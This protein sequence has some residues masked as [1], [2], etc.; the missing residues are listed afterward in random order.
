[1]V[2]GIK[3]KKAKHQIIVVRIIL[4]IR[5]QSALNVRGSTFARNAKRYTGGRRVAHIDFHGLI[6]RPCCCSFLN[7]IAR[8]FPMLMF[9]ACLGVHGR[10]FLHCSFLVAHL[11]LLGS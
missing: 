6:N 7:A 8:R 9:R 10:L 2:L 1:M 4:K 3:I 5:R 11:Q